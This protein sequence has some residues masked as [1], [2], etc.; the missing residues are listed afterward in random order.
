MSRSNEVR[1]SEF[2]DSPLVRGPLW[3][4]LQVIIQAFF[5]FWLG[6]RAIGYKRLETEQGALILANH[7]SFLDPLAVGLPFRRPVSFLARDSLFRV[8]VIGWILKKTHVMPINQQAA[9]TNSLRDTIRRLQNGWLVG[10]FPEGTRTLTGALGEMKPGFAAILRRAKLPVY[11]VGISGAYEALPMGSW[12]LKPTR[13]RVVF[14]EPISVQEL[15]KFSNRDQD[16]ELVE[17]V[18]SRIEACCEAADTWRSTGRPPE[19]LTVNA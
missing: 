12:F 15:E 1:L 18:R 11:P 17:L 4:T 14:G 5:C 2:T 3:V 9:S 13:V 16:A 8:P 7:Q 19:S 10:I 6:Y